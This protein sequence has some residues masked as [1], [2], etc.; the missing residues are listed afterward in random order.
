[1]I[2]SFSLSV[3]FTIHSRHYRNLCF[4]LI[5][6]SLIRVI[7]VCLHSKPSKVKHVCN[8][9]SDFRAIIELAASLSA[10]I[11]QFEERWRCWHTRQLW[12]MKLLLKVN[13][14]DKKQCTATKPPSLYYCE[15][16]MFI[17]FCKVFNFLCNAILARNT[18]STENAFP[19]NP[20]KYWLNIFA[21]CV[22]VIGLL[23]ALYFLFCATEPA[24]RWLTCGCESMSFKPVDSA[25]FER[26]SDYDNVLKV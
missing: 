20:H 23:M 16:E 8:I 12:T 1:M 6:P 18:Q 26:Q 5:F 21:I 13:R 7:K 4:S 19:A 14:K 10:L 2:D 25:G 11:Y 15:Y 17:C 24:V 22:A 9:S 3:I